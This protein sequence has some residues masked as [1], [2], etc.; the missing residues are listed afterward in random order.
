MFSLFLRP[1]P[2]LNSTSLAPTTR[3]VYPLFQGAIV[4]L[5]VVAGVAEK[6]CPVMH[7]IVRLRLGLW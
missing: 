2:K 3:I 4:Q 6:V 1:A 5:F 7:K